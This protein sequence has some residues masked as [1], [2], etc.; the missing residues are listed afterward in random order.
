[1]RK[2]ITT[3]DGKLAILDSTKDECVWS[4][5]WVAGRQQTRFDELY[6][7]VTKAGKKIFYEVYI[8]RWQGERCGITVIE[9]IHTWLVDHYEDLTK[10]EIARLEELGVKL[11]ETA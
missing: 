2:A 1:M 4:G 10:N 11:E 6:V 8:T 7:H 3:E 5:E 9:D